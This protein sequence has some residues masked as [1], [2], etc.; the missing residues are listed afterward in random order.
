MGLL[1]V[2]IIALAGCAQDEPT[3]P[4]TS[5]PIPPATPAPTSTT[6]TGPTSTSVP[7]RSDATN[8]SVV[9]NVS[10]EF[11]LPRENYDVSRNVSELVKPHFFA[12][13]TDGVLVEPEGDPDLVLELNG[14]VKIRLKQ[15]DQ[16]RYLDLL[17]LE[18]DLIGEH[19]V[20]K[21]FRL[22]AMGVPLAE[23]LAGKLDPD[24]FS[25]DL[26]HSVEF[27]YLQDKETRGVVSEVFPDGTFL[28]I[29]FDLP[30]E[31]DGAQPVVE[32]NLLDIRPGTRL[33]FNPSGTGAF[34]VESDTG[35]S[36]DSVLGPALSM[37]D[38]GGAPPDDGFFEINLETPFPF[39]GVDYSSIFVGSDGH[40][41]LGA[42]DGTSAGRT[43]ERHL[44]GPPRL[45]VL[46]TDLDPVCGGSVH[47]DVRS[48]RAVVTWNQVAHIERGSADGCDSDTPSNTFQAVVHA[49]G[50]IEYVYGQLD[51]EFLSQTGGNR[52]AVIGIAQG[53]TEESV[54]EVDLS[55]DL[56]LKRKIG[57]IF[58]EFRPPPPESPK[59]DLASPTH[60]HVN[61]RAL[62]AG[63]S[64]LAKQYE[65]EILAL[66]FDDQRY[67][68][69]PL[70]RKQCGVY[71]ESLQDPVYVRLLT[72][73]GYRFD[74]D[75]PG[76]DGNDDSRPFGERIS[77]L[78]RGG[79]GEKFRYFGFESSWVAG[80][81]TGLDV[82]WL[83]ECDT[84]S[85]VRRYR[86]SGAD[87]D[88]FYTIVR[89]SLVKDKKQRHKVVKLGAAGE[90]RE[91]YT[92]P[93][94]MLMALPLPWDDTRW[95][96]SSEGWPGPEEGKPADPRWQSV[97]IVD[98]N[99][100]DAYE[101]VEYPISQYPEAPEEGLYGVSAAL[102][103]DSQDL[104]NTLYGFIDEGGGL[105]AVDLTDRDFYT[106]P[107]R[108]ARIVDWDH[109]LS[110]VILEEQADGPSPSKVIFATGKEVRDD[111]AMTANLLR[112]NDAGIDS[113][114]VSKKRLLQM[115]GWNPVPFAWQ[116]LPDHRFRV[117]VETHFNYESSL[118]PR[119]KG[120]YIIPVD[121]GAED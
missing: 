48:D 16:S 33:R 88:D 8:I 76:P 73:V 105:W 53:N 46:L 90:G 94:V 96:I 23:G 121:A 77:Q 60:F 80:I 42:G 40:I 114:V 50:T 75:Q 116:Q 30:E 36:L 26:F 84:S 15:G 41:T 25:D 99:N 49:D 64:S 69:T 63:V 79:V 29:P 111:F 102:S 55:G 39:L 62:I 43:A 109:L 58:E 4:P 117:A 54:E 68:A 92:A 52:E 65:E 37:D 45:S 6:A 101:E 66:P 70:A 61:P 51:T 24:S 106:N 27:Q 10:K 67:P 115:V 12:T 19:P 74:S 17:A 28:V 32:A 81:L 108:F 103:S 97:Y 59:A 112:I 31:W 107:D 11:I 110:W 72:S 34:Q 38:G 95:M 9:G 18:S 56:P 3:P 14:K 119:A 91:I 57:A 2:G 7:P 71:Q 78:L 83:E 47:A 86:S 22:R 113:T 85:G 89:R 1:L 98:V 35:Q 20:H 93:G 82:S 104:F 5:T 120:V 13:S 21:V 100:P 118:L 87:S 44:G